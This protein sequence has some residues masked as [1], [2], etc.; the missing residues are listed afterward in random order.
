M[1]D[2]LHTM[3]HTHTHITEPHKAAQQAA[4]TALQ[5]TCA[6]PETLPPCLTVEH[7]SYQGPVAKWNPSRLTHSLDT[8]TY[9]QK[10]IHP[11]QQH[12]L[13]RMLPQDGKRRL[14]W[15]KLGQTRSVK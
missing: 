12:A 14:L 1:F 9:M 8:A 6:L 3:H 10:D 2:H 4:P 11:T 5:Q 15:E 13:A 7:N